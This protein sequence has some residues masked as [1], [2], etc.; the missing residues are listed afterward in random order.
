MGNAMSSVGYMINQINP[1]AEHVC[2]DRWRRWLLKG[3]MYNNVPLCVK[4]VGS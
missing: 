1:T 3:N 4:D 2:L